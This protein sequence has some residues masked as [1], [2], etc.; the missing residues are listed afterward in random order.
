MLHIRV[1]IY[2]FPL[3]QLSDSLLSILAIRGVEI[4][5][6]IFSEATRNVSYPLKTNGSM[7]GLY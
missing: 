6:S 7:N 1:L 3:I 5:A 2:Y 4:V